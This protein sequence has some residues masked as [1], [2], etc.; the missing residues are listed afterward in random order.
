MDHVFISYSHDDMAFATELKQHL[1]STGTLHIWLDG[2]S[3]PPG[4][5][6]SPKIEDA[7][8]E[9]YAVLLI[10]SPSSARSPHVNYEVGFAAALKLKTLP[11]L[12]REL[13]SDSQIVNHLT[14]LQWLRFDNPAA[15]PWDTLHQILEGIRREHNRALSSIEIIMKG[16]YETF[17]PEV[18]KKRLSQLA[19]ID[20]PAA[21]TELIRAVGHQMRPVKAAALSILASITNPGNPLALPTLESTLTNLNESIRQETV[22]VLAR[23]GLPAVSLLVHALHDSDKSVS[24]LASNGLL[25]I[26]QESVLPM[27]QSVRDNR[28]E[29]RVRSVLRQMADEAIPGLAKALHHENATVRETAAAV[30]NAK[31]IRGLPALL[32]GFRS[33][34]APVRLSA[35]RGMS[36]IDDRRAIETLEAAIRTDTVPLVR[37]EAVQSLGKTGTQEVV[38]PLVV[39]LHD[40]EAVV[41]K[42]ARRTLIELRDLALPELINMLQMGSLEERMLAARGLKELADPGSIDALLEALYLHDSKLQQAVIHALAAIGK[43]AVEP[44]IRVAGD[45][46]DERRIWAV[47]ALND[48]RDPRAKPVLLRGLPDRTPRIRQACAFGL[49]EL[50]QAASDAVG[51]L[52]RALNDSDK[53]VQRAAAEALKKIGIPEARA[54]YEQWRRKPV[55][56]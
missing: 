5:Q 31:G 32:D 44:L 29:S 35:V 8:R 2:A 1:E 46:K 21:Y 6:W 47:F 52:V 4:E 26:G 15:Y 49:G 56:S 36:G 10:L 19:E 34:S 17:E 41:V 13:E 37:Q 50:G 20:D 28:T 7:I 27:L 14:Q 48:I 11:L 18:C 33:G 23:I 54:A 24:M 25:Q 12:Y 53:D 42:T 43:P 30:L 39:G 22:K 9:A 38:R 51:P 45:E 40:S 16:F 3:I 55:R